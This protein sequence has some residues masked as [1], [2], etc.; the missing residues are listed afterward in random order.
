MNNLYG[1]VRS[2]CLPYGKFKWLRNADNLDVNS[3]SEKSP[4]RYIL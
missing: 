4:I 2:R 3:I 1:W